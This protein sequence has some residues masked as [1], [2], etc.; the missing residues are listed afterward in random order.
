MGKKL[1]VE[2]FQGLDFSMKYGVEKTLFC[3]QSDFQS[4]DIVET[5][6]FGKMLL[7]DGLVMVTE[8]DE[9][10]YHDMIAHVPLFTHPCPRKVLIIGGGDGGTAREVLR[11][12]VVEKCVMVEI[13]AMVVEASRTHLPSMSCSLDHPKLELRIEDGIK[14]VEETDEVFDVVLVDST[15]PIGP[16]AP[17]FGSAFYQNVY[18][19]LAETGIV[20]AQGESSH[21]EKK[22]QEKLLSIVSEIFPVR[23]LYNYH[24]LTYPGGMWS[25]AL[26]SKGPHPLKDFDSSKV[27]AS[28][29]NFRYYNEAVH[30]GA[31]ALP[32]FQKD[33][34]GGY[35][36]P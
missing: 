1:F 16:A 10:V 30:W 5:K 12:D 35:L 9:F 6:T 32:S 18:R 4:V 25:F 29:L 20:V 11:H 17:L 23:A 26:A 3:G 22:S 14:Y 34:V 31:F 7:N 13:D 8:R 33:L 21:Y 19:C 36:S 28:R 24:N 2:E 27:S 15:D